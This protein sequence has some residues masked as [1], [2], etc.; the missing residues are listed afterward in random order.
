MTTPDLKQADSSRP[1]PPA[2]APTRVTLW[3]VGLF[4]LPLL[5]LGVLGFSTVDRAL[6][7]ANERETDLLASL[8]LRS[9][10]IAAAS[11][12]ILQATLNARSVERGAWRSQVQSRAHAAHVRRTARRRAIEAT[13]WRV[14]YAWSH[15]D[16]TL[17]DIARRY[18]LTVESLAELNPA[19]HPTDIPPGTRVILY[20]YDRVD[21]PVSA[22]KANRGRL[23]SAVPMPIGDEWVIRDPARA[24]GTDVMIDALVRGFRHV[25]NTFPDT[26]P[27]YLGD[28]SRQRG[29]A[30]RPHKSHQSGRDVDASYYDLESPPRTADRFVHMSRHTIDIPRQWE[31]FSYWIRN[32]DVTH[33]FIDRRL[34]PAFAEYAEQVESEEIMERAF[35]RRP[36]VS[37]QPGHLNHFHARF[38]C[39]E[40]DER[41]EE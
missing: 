36:I 28:L 27:V 13:G 38:R 12:P 16:D 23:F 6:A 37:H 25:S 33:I 1:A 20:H 30:F 9:D 3:R 4:A 22:G 41:C 35:G 19:L 32:D 2:S 10:A 7:S 5:L 11:A 18:A 17:A 34:I 21:P 26:H 40:H 14:Q 24:W 31:L 15:P 29:G 8:V 39:A